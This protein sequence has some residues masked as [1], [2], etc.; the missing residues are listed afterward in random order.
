[1][2]LFFDLDGTL[3]DVSRRY[4][5]AHVRAL[6]TNSTLTQERYWLLKRQQV[7]E[8]EI[9]KQHDPMLDPAPYLKK[10]L[11][12]IESPELLELDSV[13]PHVPE[14]LA[15]LKAQDIRLVLV[16][17]RH[18]RTSLT[19]ELAR[20]GLTTFF[21]EVL[22]HAGTKNPWDVKAELLRPLAEKTDWIIGDTEADIRAGNFLGLSTCAVTSGIRTAEFLRSLQPTLLVPSISDASL[23]RAIGGKR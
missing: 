16:T 10:R 22:T 21:S 19:E 17:L 1:M 2:T 7:P 3:I 8:T 6:G 12:L 11:E 9:L 23:L 18:D 14:T 4:F 13:L 15:I 5:D 20:L